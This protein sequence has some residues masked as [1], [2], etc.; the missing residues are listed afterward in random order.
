VTVLTEAFETAAA[1]RARVLG[2]PEHRAVVVE[3]PIASRTG[4][5]VEKMAVGAAARVVAALTGSG[6]A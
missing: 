4:P 2:L 3:H 6:E 1:A 5:E